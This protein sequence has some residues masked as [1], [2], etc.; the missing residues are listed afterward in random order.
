M[1][2]RCSNKN[3][4]DFKHY[5]GRG[6]SVCEEWIEF[7]RGQLIMFD[8]GIPHLSPEHSL[9]SELSGHGL[10]SD[11]HHMQPLAL[12]ED[13]RRYQAKRISQTFT[14]EGI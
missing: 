9:D 13:T 8:D 1:K 12:E 7:D 2:S 6:I 14:A 10:C 11:Y 5:G 3:R 4:H